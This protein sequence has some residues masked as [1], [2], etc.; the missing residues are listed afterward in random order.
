MLKLSRAEA[1]LSELAGTFNFDITTDLGQVEQELQNQINKNRGRARVAA[2]LSGQGVE[3]IQREEAVEA[4][5]A[6]DALKQ[7]EV[8]MGLISPQTANI[9]QEQ[10]DLGP[11]QRATETN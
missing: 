9:S 8:D 2:D 4:A 11:A 7:F 10:K 3:Q 1:E 5:M 6:E